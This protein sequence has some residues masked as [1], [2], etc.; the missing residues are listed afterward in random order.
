LYCHDFSPSLRL[1]SQPQPP[2]SVEHN[3]LLVKIRALF[4][5]SLALLHTPSPRRHSRHRRRRHLVFGLPPAE[6]R[7]SL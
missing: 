3:G 7:L 2:D 6:E 1:L 4:S 5:T